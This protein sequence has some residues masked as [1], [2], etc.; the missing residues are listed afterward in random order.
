M[1]AGNRL[2]G[3]KALVYIDGVELT[4][5][6]GYSFDIA[7]DTAEASAFG[8]TWKT[9]LGGLIGASGSLDGLLEHDKKTLF[10]AT[11]K[12]PCNSANVMIY[13]NRS[14]SSDVF[15]FDAY[16]GTG[17]AGDVGSAQ[18]NKA[19]FTV[20]GAVTLTGFS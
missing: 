1:S 5:A 2:H 6:R 16:F 12:G 11:T 17:Y 7:H 8:E 18:S 9:I 14:D 19:T 20:K 3:L 4:G 15:S 10:T 13:P